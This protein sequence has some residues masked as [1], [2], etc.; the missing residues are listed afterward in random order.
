[1]KEAADARAAGDPLR[2]AK[3][4]RN[5]AQDVGHIV[6]SALGGTVEE[7]GWVPLCTR[8]NRGEAKRI[9]NLSQ[10]MKRRPVRTFGVAETTGHQL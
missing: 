6:P 9:A 2:C 3:C 8:C 5:Y 4:R 1:M 7:H 10:Q